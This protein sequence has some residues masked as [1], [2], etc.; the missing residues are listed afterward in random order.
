MKFREGTPSKEVLERIKLRWADGM[1]IDHEGF[2]ITPSSPVLDPGLYDYKRSLPSKY[3]N[4]GILPFCKAKL[5]A[6]DC[7]VPIMFDVT[8]PPAQHA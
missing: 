3:C 7:K 2:E 1:I 4:T 5:Y 6:S 8:F